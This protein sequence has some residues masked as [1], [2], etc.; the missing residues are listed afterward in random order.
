MRPAPGNRRAG[1]WRRRPVLVA[2]L[3]LALCAASCGPGGVLPGFTD[4]A[5]ASF[6]DSAEDFPELGDV[7]RAFDRTVSPPPGTRDRDRQLDLFAE[8]FD[9][10]RSDY[11]EPVS[12]QAAVLLALEG[13]AAA[14]GEAG[15]HDLAGDASA[16]DS[17]RA[18]DALMSAGLSGMLT[19]LDPHSGYLDPGN[20]REMQLRSRGEFGGIGIEVTMQDGYVRVVAPID[21]TPGQRAGLQSGDLITR[22]DG[23]AVLGLSLSDAVGLMRGRAGTVVRLDVR[24]PP[25]TGTFPV[26]ITRAV[27]RVHAVRARAEGRVGYLRITTFNER[28]E[29]GVRRAVRDLAREIDGELGWVIDLRNNPGGLL[30]QALGVTDVFLAGGEIVFTRGRGREASRRFP[31]GAD[32]LSGN[33][34]IVVLINGGSASAAEIVSGALQDHDRALVIGTRSFGKGSVQTIMPVSGGGAVRLTT[35]RYYTPSGRSIQSTG[36][37]PDILAEPDDG[38]PLRE[39]DLDNALSAET[40]A[41]AA[42][43]RRLADVCPEQVADEDPALACAIWLLERQQILAGA[44][45]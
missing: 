39:S 29:Q 42:G 28:A 33:L 2:G 6:E 40:G 10:I 16:A 9:M 19:G 23:Q 12:A 15:L 26:T 36:I 30:D 38:A 17:P 32:D 3:G 25:A 35:A 20:Y 7:A 45:R 22:V 21:D 8:V 31:A 13:F 41:D 5:R 44:L 27:V 1:R 11:V 4:S 43:V 37:M 34:P 14:E 18:A 24:R